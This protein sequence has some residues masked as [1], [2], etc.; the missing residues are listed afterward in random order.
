MKKL[1]IALVGLGRIGWGTHLP[2]IA[3]HA[4]QYTLVG[5]V[6]L[7]QDRLAEA[8]A[9]YGVNGYTD[10]AAMIAAEHP[11]L[12]VIASPTH[13]HREHACTC[14]ELGCDVFLDKPMAESYESA[15]AIARCSQETGRKLM[16]FQP[17][18]AH[19]DTNQLMALIAE[20]KIGPLKSIRFTRM[21]YSRRS[22]WQSFKKFGGG[23]LTNYGA[24]HIDQ[25]LYMTG[26][27]IRRLYCN[28]D[29]V[30]TSGD[31]D[32]VARIMLQTESGIRLDID[33]NQ[34]AALVDTEWHIYGQYGAIRSEKS[35]EGKTQFRMRYFDPETVPAPE[36]SENLAAADR[37][38]NHDVALPWQEE[39]IPLDSSY[40]IDFYN[41]VYEYFGEDKAPFV[42]VEQTLYLMDLIRRCHED[43]ES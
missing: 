41:K 39:I 37:K 32:D 40:A 30:A 28:T 9:Q 43:A 42:P 18:R 36:A 21:N 20:N 13:M 16:I 5:V 24:H 1:T 11:D 6:D 3:Q 8:K 27:K 17:V 35:P 12:V 34:A 33:I 7:A 14:M 19:A 26:E 31:A 38:Y 2:R 22:D 25:M 29:V 15:C 10:I 23:M 4:E